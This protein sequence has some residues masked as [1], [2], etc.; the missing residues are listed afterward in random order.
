M[1]ISIE[2]PG[3]STIRTVRSPLEYTDT[4]PP[5][6]APPPELGEHT[7]AVLTRAG[8]DA[9]AIAGFREQGIIP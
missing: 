5:H 7:E 8:Y 2:R 1:E 3:K 9:A 6:P 4:P